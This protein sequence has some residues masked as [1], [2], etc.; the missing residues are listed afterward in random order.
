[1]DIV[2]VAGGPRGRGVYFYEARTGTFMLPPA[3]V[4]GDAT[5]TRGRNGTLM[6]VTHIPISTFAKKV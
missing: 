3:D 4:G 2:G 6:D 5:G 1:V